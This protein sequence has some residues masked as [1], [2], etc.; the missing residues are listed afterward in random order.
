MARYEDDFVGKEDRH[1]YR[2]QLFLESS[3]RAQVILESLSGKK[4]GL[5]YI[6]LEAR[7]AQSYNDLT[8]F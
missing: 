4:G 1:M 8:R 6:K 5:L 7:T 2:Y 3:Q